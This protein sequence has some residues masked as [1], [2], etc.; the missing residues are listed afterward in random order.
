MTLNSN[1]ESK[2][3]L[4]NGILRVTCVW[5]CDPRNLYFCKPTEIFKNN[6]LFAY[7]TNRRFF[8]RLHT[9]TIFS[10]TS[11]V[12]IPTVSDLLQINTTFIN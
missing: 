3:Y 1:K 10:I 7:A 8:L 9:L 6:T 2:L 12:V 5:S 4:R 11:C